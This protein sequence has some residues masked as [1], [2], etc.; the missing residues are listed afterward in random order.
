MKQTQNLRNILWLAILLAA[1]V[2]SASGRSP[3]EFLTDEEIDLIRIK[4]EIAPRVEYYLQA[5]L[6]RLESTQARLL[7]EETI[8]GDPMEYFTPEGMLDGYYR[9]LNSVMLNLEDS[10]QRG[11][12]DRAGIKKALKELRKR[13]EE[14]R[15]LLENLKK[16]A[17]ERDDKEMGRLIL[18]A[19][20]ITN[21]AHEGA[22]HA[23]D[24]KTYE[25]D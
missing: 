7:G 2:C 6:L 5:A 16:L 18:R 17:E 24:E 3:G 20:D 12:S 25:S 14:S 4:Q 21:S 15:R 13:T 9:I 19:I 23:L 1:A 10:F 11:R 8:P 22:V